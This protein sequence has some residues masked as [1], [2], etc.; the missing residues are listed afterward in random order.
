MSGTEFWGCTRF[1]QCK[2]SLNL[3]GSV[4]APPSVRKRTQKA[5]KTASTINDTSPPTSGTASRRTSKLK[6]GDLLVSSANDLGP[7]KLVAKDGDRLVLEYF[8][9]PGQ[10]PSERLRA[11]VPR[12]SLRRL[13]LSL[14][15]ESSG[16][17]TVAGNLA[18]Y[19]KYLASEM[20][21][22]VPEAATNT[23]LSSAST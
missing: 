1:P 12:E 16:L 19:C 17:Q 8:D 20:W 6:R 15:H 10:D 7:G 13:P 3:D 22:Y 5:A 18:E 9:T 2:G 23:L 4:P 11:S 14:K 21:K